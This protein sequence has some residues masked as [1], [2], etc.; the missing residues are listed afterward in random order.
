MPFDL[1]GSPAESF[2]TVVIGP[3]PFLDV[4]GFALKFVEALGELVPLI[5]ELSELC[6]QYDIGK[7]QSTVL[8]IVAKIAVLAITTH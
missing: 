1:I 8:V 7:V 3:L 6:Q 5:V 2:L 4:F